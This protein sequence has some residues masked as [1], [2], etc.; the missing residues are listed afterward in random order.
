VHVG[1][2]SFLC[3]GSLCRR[4]ANKRLSLLWHGT[5]PSSDSVTERRISVDTCDTLSNSTLAITEVTHSL[6]HSATHALLVAFHSSTQERVQHLAAAA[7]RDW[8]LWER[9]IEEWQQP[10]CDD[11]SIPEWYKCTLFNELYYVTAGGSVWVEEEVLP[12]GTLKPNDSLRAAPT[13]TSTED[14]ST[15]LLPISC[16]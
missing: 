15:F 11:P 2:R 4:E 5:C 6:T 1:S 12:D 10:I 9:A 8:R 14:S 13:D 7:L 3:S 16:E